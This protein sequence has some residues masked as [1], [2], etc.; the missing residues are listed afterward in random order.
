MAGW[1]GLKQVWPAVLVAGGSFAIVQFAVSQTHGPMLV[2]V[3]GGLVSLVVMGIFLKFWQPKEIWHF[4]GEPT[5]IPDPVAEAT[6]AEAS[7]ELQSAPRMP[8]RSAMLQYSRGEVAQAWVPWLLMSLFVFLW[9]TPQFRSF[10]EGPTTSNIEV[11]ALHMHIRRSEPVA[12]PAA[13][14]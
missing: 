2:D 10:V 7:G 3:A 4:A 6:G 12:S 8:P 1:R 14:P 11:R 9:G 13:A 5:T